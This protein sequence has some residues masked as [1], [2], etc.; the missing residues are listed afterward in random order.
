MYDVFQIIGKSKVTSLELHLDDLF[1]YQ[2]VLDTY[3]TDLLADPAD[4]T[5]V[6]NREATATLASNAS[7][8]LQAV[9]ITTTDI[10]KLFKD[11]DEPKI[12]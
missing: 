9:P 7:T 11:F 2:G 4:A 1:R 5:L 12:R 8:T 10:I 6:T 3:D